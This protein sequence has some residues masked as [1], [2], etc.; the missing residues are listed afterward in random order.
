[1]TFTLDDLDKHLASMENYNSAPE[2]RV[3]SR[4][5]IRKEFIRLVAEAAESGYMRDL[6]MEKVREYVTLQLQMEQY[7]EEHKQRKAKKDAKKA[8]VVRTV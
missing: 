3:F 5:E 8:V 6:L 7:I 4:E 1:M 2:D